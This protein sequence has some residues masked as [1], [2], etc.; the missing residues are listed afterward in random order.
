MLELVIG[1]VVLAFLWRKICCNY[2]VNFPP[3]PR[4]PLPVIGDIWTL[5]ADVNKGV[6]RLVNRYGRIVGLKIGSQRAV[7]LAS[8]D[9]IL[10][11]FGREEFSGRPAFP[12]PAEGKGTS[13]DD[14]LP[15]V[16]GSSGQTWTEQRRFATRCLK[17]LGL[18]KSTMEDLVAEEVD[19]VCRELEKEEG[20]YIQLRGRFHIP[21]L[22]AIWRVLT[23]EKLDHDDPRLKSLLANIDRQVYEFA[24][25][26]FL[27]AA[28]RPDTRL[29][30]L[31]ERLGLIKFTCTLLPLF[32]FIT[33]AIDFHYQTYQDDSMRDFLDMYIRK[34]KD[35]EEEFV[36]STFVG[37]AGQSNMKNIMLDLLV[38][39]SDTTSTTLSWAFL[40]MLRHPECLRNVQGE[41][42]SVCGR[43]RT[44]Q[45]SDRTNTPY[46]LAVI[47]EIH[48]MANMVFLIPAHS[49]LKDTTLGGYDIP[50]GTQI[51]ASPGHHM[52]DPEHFPHPRKFDPERYLERMPES[53]TLRFVPNPRVIPFSLG[54]RRCMGEMLANI[55]LYLFFSGVVHKFNIEPAPGEELSTEYLLSAL[56]TP[57]P[58]KAKFT[59]RS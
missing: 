18:G 28:T 56:L 29:Y 1:F 22:T 52:T 4:W 27:I 10:E 5:G 51:L 41:L 59:L 40:Y 30:R 12:G 53:G 21:I 2:P 32:E 49:T 33:K 44:P 23:N 20:K 13:G 36:R 39:G 47:Q 45:W 43:S 3:G 7:L 26:F 57:K 54:R 15:G 31:F 6:H 35:D 9:L 11:A 58:Y 48:R 37:K 14:G 46:T 55:E 42:D 8:Y 25:P 19:A 50:A 16:F 34:R 38:G 24:S 17:D